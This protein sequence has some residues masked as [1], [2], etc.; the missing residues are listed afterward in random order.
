LTH[1]L[2]SDYFRLCV[3]FSVATSILSPRLSQDQRDSLG[4]NSGLCLRWIA[5]EHL[6][7]LQY[8]RSLFVL[9]W[10]SRMFSGRWMCHAQLP[11]SM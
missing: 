9:T 3:R 4:L 11:N 10:T 8:H 7:Y 2:I 5:D 1:S 6:F